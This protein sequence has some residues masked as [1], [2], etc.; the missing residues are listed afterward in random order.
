MMDSSRKA[1]S[2]SFQNLIRNHAHKPEPG[3]PSSMCYCLTSRLSDI[4]LNGNDKPGDTHNWVQYGR[5]STNIVDIGAGGYGHE[6]ID[7][8][9]DTSKCGI[10]K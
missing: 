8:D 5:G 3:P 2:R 4:I 6:L 10:V 9:R 1:P 7:Q